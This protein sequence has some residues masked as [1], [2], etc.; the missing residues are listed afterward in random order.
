MNLSAGPKVS[1]PAYLR[2]HC[3]RVLPRLQLIPELKSWLQ[4]ALETSLL[5]EHRKIT[6]YITLWN[7][8]A[9]GAPLCVLLD[10]LGAPSS[11]AHE[12]LDHDN[13]KLSEPERLVKT[14]IDGVRLLEIQ[15]R[16]SFGE[17]FRGED[18]FNGTHQGFAKVRNSNTYNGKYASLICS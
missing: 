18:L 3:A 4:I 8:F 9:L 14:F 10:L 5:S 16:L 1:P 6:P 7:C 13:G 15:G 2:V 11:H 12:D 17:V